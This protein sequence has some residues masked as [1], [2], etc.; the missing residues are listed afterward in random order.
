MRWGGG[1]TGSEETARNKSRE[2]SSGLGM[3]M[4][5]EKVNESES[6]GQPEGSERRV[7]RCGA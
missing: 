6:W 3:I 7:P 5:R 2:H 1:G 4:G